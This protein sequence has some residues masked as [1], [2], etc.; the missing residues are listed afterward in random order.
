MDTDQ[1]KELAPHYIVMLLLVFL[2]LAIVRTVAGDIGFW[3]E[4]AIIAIVVFAYRPIVVQL[5]LGPSRWEE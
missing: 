1:L 3:I 4:F 5:G 2:A